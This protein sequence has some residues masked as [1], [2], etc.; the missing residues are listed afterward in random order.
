[1]ASWQ[2][3]LTLSITVTLHSGQGLHSICD[4]DDTVT[5]RAKSDDVQQICI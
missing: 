5:S 1:M 2:P 3:V 4:K